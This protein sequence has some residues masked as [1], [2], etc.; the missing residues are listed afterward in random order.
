MAKFSKGQGTQ[1]F[2]ITS[3]IDTKKYL[4]KYLRLFKIEYVKKELILSF[5]MLKAQPFWSCVYAAVKPRLLWTTD[6]ANTILNIILAH[7]ANYFCKYL[8]LVVGSIQTCPWFCAWTTVDHMIILILLDF[9]NEESGFCYEVQS[10]S[11]W[12][13]SAIGIKHYCSFPEFVERMLP[14]LWPR[15]SVSTPFG[16]LQDWMQKC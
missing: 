10:P 5:L 6:I 1:Q 16:K 11:M 2:R 3:E 12:S 14:S 9:I 7:T 15:M 8:D 13:S 4:K